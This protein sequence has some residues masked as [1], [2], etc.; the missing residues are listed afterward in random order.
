M[1]TFTRKKPSDEIFSGEMSLKDWVKKSFSDAITDVLDANLLREDKDFIGKVNCLSSI[2]G[3]ALE[4]TA[5]LPEERKNMKDVVAIL[6]KIK[7][8]F[9]KDIELAS[10][11]KECV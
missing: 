2:M 11:G 6:Q 8:K 4:C 1:E 3:L 9:L 5:K 10:N 7:M